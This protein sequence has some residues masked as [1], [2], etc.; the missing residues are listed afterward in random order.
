M[1]IVNLNCFEKKTKERGSFLKNFLPQIFNSSSIVALA[2]NNGL[3]AIN[4]GYTN[5]D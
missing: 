5:N 4:S 1:S 3:H 2:G